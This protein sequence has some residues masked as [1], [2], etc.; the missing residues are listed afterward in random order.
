MPEY[1]A[2]WTAFEGGLLAQCV[3]PARAP[4]YPGHQCRGWFADVGQDLVYL[5]RIHPQAGRI[6]EP[7]PTTRTRSVHKCT[8]CGTH[9]EYE[10]VHAAVKAS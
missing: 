8:K 6:A 1:P 10:V 2:G 5:V 4:R 7:K 3:A 9:L